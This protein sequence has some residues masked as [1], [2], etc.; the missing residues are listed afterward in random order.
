M[1]KLI[2]LWHC[3]EVSKSGFL[4]RNCS[5]EC[6]IWPHKLLKPLHSKKHHNQSRSPFPCPRA[7]SIIAFLNAVTCSSWKS[8]ARVKCLQMAVVMVP[9]QV[10]AVL[11][12][13]LGPR[14][15]RGPRQSWGG[16]SFRIRTNS[17]RA[18][19]QALL[20]QLCCWERVCTDTPLPGLSFNLNC[21]PTFLHP[22]LLS[23][24][25]ENPR[26]S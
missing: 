1:Q 4:D 18:K 14:W 10:S 23:P 21:A 2:G 13:A 12:S 25:F 15:Q 3:K 8:L 11:G 24:N 17:W 16:R 5:E 19:G 20:Q 6:Y 26:A 22:S 7:L 9:L